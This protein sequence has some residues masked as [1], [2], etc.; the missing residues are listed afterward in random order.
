V[1]GMRPPIFVR[2][3]SDTKKEQLQTALGSSEAYVIRRAQ[4]I[5]A[6]HRGERASQIARSLGCGQQT[7][8][9]HP[10]P[11]RSQMAKVEL[12]SIV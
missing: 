6:S 5:L 7:G 12:Y 8:E 3:L 2:L 10:Y 1:A 11:V 4:T 9:E